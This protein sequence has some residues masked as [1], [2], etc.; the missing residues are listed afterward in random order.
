MLFVDL[1]DFKRVNDLHGHQVGDELLATLGGRLLGAVRPAD[2]V[3]RMGG[4]EFVVVCEQIDVV[5]ALAL[6]D[7][8]EAAIAEPVGAGGT[9]HRLSASIGVALGTRRRRRAAAQRGRRRL[10]GQGGRGRAHRGLQRELS[11]A[12]PGRRARVRPGGAERG[13]ISLVTS[14]V[15]SVISSTMSNQRRVRSGCRRPR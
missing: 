11:C 5:G 12:S 14:P 4:D 6:A 10:P 1:D 7:R 9:E 15:S 13:T 2:T 3:A 8:L